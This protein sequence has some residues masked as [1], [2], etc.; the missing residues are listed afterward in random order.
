MCLCVRSDKLLLAITSGV[1]LGSWSHGT[2]DHILPICFCTIFCL[3]NFRPTLEKTLPPT[4]EC[5]VFYV[6]CAML[7]ERKQSV[8]PRTSFYNSGTICQIS[9]HGKL[10]VQLHETGTIKKLSLSSVVPSQTAQFVLDKTLMS[11]HML[12]TWATL[13]SLL[14]LHH[15]DKRQLGTV[16][17]K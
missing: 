6:V 4:A 7:K 13:L 16:P 14:T 17:G 1:I 12:G 11:E 2:H 10:V 15:G 3:C 8:F 5:I 9:Q